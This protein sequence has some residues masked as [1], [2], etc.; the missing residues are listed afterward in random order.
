MSISTNLRDYQSAADTFAANNNSFLPKTKRWF[1]IYF[2]INPNAVSVVNQAFVNGQF[3]PGARFN[4]SGKQ[5]DLALIGVLAKSVK[6]PDISFEVKKHNQYNRWSLNVEKVNYSQIDISFW[7]DTINTIDSF[8]YAYYQYMNQDPKYSNFGAAQT[9]GLPIPT[10]WDQTANNYSTIYNATD[11]F[12]NNWG[13]DTVINGSTS[14]GRNQPFFQSIRI[15]QFNRSVSDKKGA[16]Y[17]EFVLVNPVITSFGHD[18]LS[19][20]SDDFCANSMKI[21]YETVLY[22]AGYMNDD[23]IASWNLVTSTYY[24]NSA[25]PNDLLIGNIPLPIPYNS[26]I[27]HANEI[28]QSAQILSL[29]VTG[30]IHSPGTAI[31]AIGSTVSA[32]SLAL[33][34][35][36]IVPTVF[37]A[38]GAGG[39][40]PIL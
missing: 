26:T 24:D 40:P 28:I 2:Q 29:P 17:N 15:Y 18:T 8:W 1:H 20:E 4:W 37:N 14:F 25:S 23:E 9:Q 19:Y 27:A 12:A 7:D 35:D 36:I 39:N 31:T 33:G 34:T 11:N 16:S 22:N 32:A 21:D 13:L 3:G 30:Y 6:L 38:L 5:S 10:Q